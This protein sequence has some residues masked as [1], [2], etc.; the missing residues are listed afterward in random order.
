MVLEHLTI[1]GRHTASIVADL[2][3]RRPPSIVV[4][5][6]DLKPKGGRPAADAIADYT[7][8]LAEFRR[9]TQ[10][11]AA[12]RSSPLRHEHPWFGPLDVYQ[13]LCFAP[14]HQTIHVRQA[15]RIVARATQ[16]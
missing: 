8:M 3:E 5:T 1:V 7:A 4:R 2:L 12:R 10:V 6:A 15:R 16:L 14:F 9:A 11:D 13:W